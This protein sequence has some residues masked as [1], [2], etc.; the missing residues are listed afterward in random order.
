M[1]KIQVMTAPR[2]PGQR[3]RVIGTLVDPGNDEAPFGIG[4]GSG[5]LGNDP[6]MAFER[7]WLGWSN[8]AIQTKAVQP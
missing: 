5:L 1:R 8:G 3:P 4:A 6:K 2:E 7:Y